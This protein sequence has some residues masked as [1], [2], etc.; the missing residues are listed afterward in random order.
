MFKIRRLIKKNLAKIIRDI[1]SFFWNQGL[2][3]FRK[4]SLA[5]ISLMAWADRHSEFRFHP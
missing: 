5:G 2:G 3:F 1:S 4:E